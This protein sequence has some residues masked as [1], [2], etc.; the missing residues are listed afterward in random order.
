M[1]RLFLYKFSEPLYELWYVLIL[2]EDCQ[3][4]NYVTKILKTWYLLT[5]RIGCNSIVEELFI[6]EAN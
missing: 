1:F 5:L 3:G 2:S 6:I 4:L